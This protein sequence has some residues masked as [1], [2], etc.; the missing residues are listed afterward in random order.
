MFISFLIFVISLAGIIYFSDKFVDYA[1]HL[2]KI[3]KLSSMTIGLTVVAIGT[4]L[5]EAITCA[6]ATLRGYPQIALNNVVGSN[7]CNVGLIVGL[8]AIFGSVVCARSVVIRD[9]LV[10]V[11]VSFLLL[12][13]AIFNGV[14]DTTLSAVFLLGFMAYLYWCFVKL[15]QKDAPKVVVVDSE[16][17][18]SLSVTIFFSMCAL[19]MVLICSEFL[20]SSTLELAKALGISENI[21]ALT[22]IAVG[23]S[24][25]ELSVSISSAKKG[26]GDLLVGSIVGSNITNILLV[27]GISA[28]ITPIELRAPEMLFLDMPIMII[29]AVLMFVYLYTKEGIN[30]SRG[31]FLLSLYSFG[32]LRS[33]LIPYGISGN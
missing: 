19:A 28:S 17:N 25:P 26:Q 3:L 14:L 31:I 11:L 10:M 2:A 20:I 32:L 7:I 18:L 29:F 16:K 8:S 24:L 6:L 22:L 5:P 23:T 21:I 27:L 13:L 9:G 33:V 30:L 4:S 15:P 12:L 1:V